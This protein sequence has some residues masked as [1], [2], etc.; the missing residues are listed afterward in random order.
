MDDVS[1]V[2]GNMPNAEFF[3]YRLIGDRAHPAT[4]WWDRLRGG[5]G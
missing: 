1:V 3:P 5:V 2:G 4:L